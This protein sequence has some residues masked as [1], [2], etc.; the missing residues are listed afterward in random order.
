MRVKICGCSGGETPETSLTGFVIDDTLA[1]DAG[2]LCKAL[3]LEEQCALDNVLITHTH[4]DHIKDLAFLADNIIGIKKTPLH[5][6]GAEPVIRVLREHFMNDRI[7]P[8]FTKIPTAD[9]PTLV[10][11]QI[12]PEK[13]FEVAGYK[14]LA[15]P[16]KHPVP[17]T[18]YIVSNATGAFCFTGDTGVTERIWEV[19][20]QTPKVL[21]LITEVSFPNMMTDLAN[22]SG[23][24]T[25]KMLFEQMGRLKN[26]NYTVYLSHNKPNFRELLHK[27][28]AETGL[29]DYYFLTRGELLDLAP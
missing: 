4:L 28:V 26:R 18:G 8:D 24:L 2:S 1:L 3:T 19:L 11:H 14:V 9:N 5:I 20:N 22:L 23:H 29:Q 21:G 12:E 6:W 15:V 13:P 27:E 16:T 10:Y 7:W 17:N 25:P